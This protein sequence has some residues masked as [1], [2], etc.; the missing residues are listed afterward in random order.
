MKKTSLFLLITVL[1]L[2]LTG[3][4][5][6]GGTP[7][8]TDPVTE[9][10]EPDVTET[11]G[12]SET[13]SAPE[14]VPETE[15]VPETAPETAEPPQ[16][17]PEP[18]ETVPET[19]KEPEKTVT[20]SAVGTIPGTG[21]LYR[22]PADNGRYVVC[23]DAGHQG[24]GMND[25]EPNAP[26]SDVMKAKVTSGTAGAFTGLAEHELNLKVAL[27]LRDLLLERGYSVLMVRESADVTISNAERAILANENGASIL[28]RIHANGASDPS[29]NGAM[30]LCQTPSNPDNGFCYPEAR[31]LS[32]T[33][34]SAFCETTGMKYLYISETDTMTGINWCKVPATIIEMGFMS[35]EHDDRYMAES[36]FA[37]L[38][39]KGIADGV[40]RFYE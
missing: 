30:T 20:V 21:I 6:H 25:T 24:H 15:P 26:G 1:L 12:V 32:E 14:T 40:D 33:V 8:G 31:H 37:L 36:S 38:A 39:A 10:E 29:V 3:C 23:I 28:I 16:T 27:C 13:A 11:E 17:E 4:S 35:N 2:A 19:E 34:L 5:D 18:E 22:N 9:T 7:A